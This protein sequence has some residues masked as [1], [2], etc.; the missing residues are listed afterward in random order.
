MIR[1]MLVAPNWYES[2]ASSPPVRFLG[3]HP[4]GT[5]PGDFAI[6]LKRADIVPAQAGGTRY[7]TQPLRPEGGVWKDRLC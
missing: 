3:M 4:K 6:I 1:S 5:R 7:P 2:D